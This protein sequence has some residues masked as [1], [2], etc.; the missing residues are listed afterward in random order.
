MAKYDVFNP[1]PIMLTIGDTDIEVV[2]ET[3]WNVK[4]SVQSKPN[5]YT[6]Q[7]KEAAQK[8]GERSEGYEFTLDLLTDRLHIDQLAVET[9]IL[10]A[11]IGMYMIV[12]K[13]HGAY[14][15]LLYGEGYQDLKDDRYMI[16][17]MDKYFRQA[18]PGFQRTSVASHDVVEELRC[19]NNS[20]KH[21]GIV[22]EK[23]AS[24]NPFWKQDDR[25]E[26][27]R[28]MERLQD[29]KEHVPRYLSDLRQKLNDNFDPGERDK[30]VAKHKAKNPAGKT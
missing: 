19:V 24:T 25:I 29:Y 16:K 5:K 27:T 8:Y 6:E 14:L 4:K 30:V 2:M 11:P 9:V 22:D 13:A 20:I 21:S 28:I 7:L 3:V 17:V 10:L 26:P 1:P 15:R 23:L 12:E 18:C